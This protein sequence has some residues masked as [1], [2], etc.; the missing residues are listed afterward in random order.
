MNEVTRAR[1]GRRILLADDDAVIQQ[2]VQ[3]LAERRGHELLQANTGRGALALAITAQPDIIVLDLE[4]PDADGR[5]ILCKLKADDRTKHIPVVVW[6]GRDG[7]GSDSKISLSRGAEDFVEK[8]EAG[9]LLL[10]LERVLLRLDQERAT[11]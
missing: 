9:L 1:Q 2:V 6:S 4:F 5:D 3:R 10:K 7:H 11:G 8:G